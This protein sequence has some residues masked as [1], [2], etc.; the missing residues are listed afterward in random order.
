GTVSLADGTISIDS[1]GATFDF[2]A[3][4]LQWSGGTIDA[5]GGL[6]VNQ[7]TIDVTPAAGNQTILVGTL[8]N[9]A[10]V[11]QSGAG[12]FGFLNGATFQ[13]DSSGT[14]DLQTDGG[15][16]CYQ[17]DGNATFSNAGL[18]VKSM[19]TGDSSFFSV[20]NESS[21]VA[22]NNSGTLE[23]E[24][25][26]LTV[27]TGGTFTGGNFIVDTGATL[28]P[29]GSSTVTYTG[30]FTGSGG[31]S[32]T[33]ASGQITIASGGATF[34][35]PS[36]FFQWTGGTIN[37][38][39]A[40]LTNADSMTVDPSAGNETLLVGAMVNDGTVDQTTTGDFGMLNAATFDNESGATYDFLT[41]GGMGCY[42]GDGNATF[43]NSGT[44]TKTGGTGTSSFFSVPNESSNVILNNTGVV[45]AISGSLSF[46]CPVTQV[47]SDTL[48]GG[49]W[50]AI[51]GA[52][53]NLPSGTTITENDAD[54]TLEGAGAA[55]GGIAGLANNVG[56]FTVGDGAA[57]TTS[58]GLTNNGLIT[59]KS[60]SS[61]TVGGAFVQSSGGTLAYLLNGTPSSGSFGQLLVQQQATL[62][63]TVDVA[64]IN[65]YSPAVGDQFTVAAYPSVSGTFSTVEGPSVNGNQA[66]TVGVNSTDITV[67]WVAS[68]PST[69]SVSSG[70]VVGN[71]SGNNANQTGSVMLSGDN[72]IITI[73]GNTD[74]IPLS[75]ATTVDLTM[76]GGNDSVTLGEGV[77]PVSVSGGAGNDTIVGATGDDTI[78][79]GEGDDSISAISGNNV[80]S[81]GSGADT[82]K[83]G[84]GGDSLIGGLGADYLISGTGLN[85][86]SGGAGDDTIATTGGSDQVLRGGAGNNIFVDGEGT[87]ATIDGGS[88]FSY[89]QQNSGD[90]MNNILEEFD[91]TPPIS[92]P[93]APAFAPAIAAAPQDDSAVTETIIGTELFISGTPGND[94]IRVNANGSGDLL[95]HANG[96]AAVSFP[97]AGLTSIVIV[98]GAG[99]D[100]L[101]VASDVTLQARIRGN[102]GNDCLMGGGGDNILVGGIGSDT[103]VGGAG[104]N[105]LVPTLREI[106]TDGSGESDLLVGGPAGS[107]NI[108][109]FSHRTDNLYLSNDGA[110]H[111][112]VTIMPSVLNIFAGTGQ[113]TVAATAPGMFISAGVGQD[114]LVSGGSNTI[115]V[116]GPS[117]AGE[118]TVSASGIANSLFL[119]NGHEDEYEGFTMQDF[120]QDDPSDVLI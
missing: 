25:G 58:G 78:V 9:Q 94:S 95:V 106:F 108:A 116:A 21:N 47:S 74:A 79:G 39:A 53:I 105:L 109:D 3:G 102:A 97:E 66:F 36:L 98:G 65:G 67:T 77:P 43:N 56:S 90:V 10:S 28:D 29:A 118:D 34:D 91:P 63:G 103:L 4:L 85:T 35:F 111:N 23:V 68:V 75:S 110:D 96:A 40:A 27:G 107:K 87:G 89:A 26:T 82:I 32:V 1:A 13:N 113:D 57:F 70:T 6:L 16:G 46:D 24:T 2:P 8:E 83:G 73:D 69:I 120:L 71:G 119:M 41:D 42:Q 84:T 100:T 115:M 50:D 44:L 59:L 17:G 54:I 7:G 18:L 15:F 45:S 55:F 76:G 104:Q 92:P 48:T 88:G 14:Y 19:G 64:P 38:T 86:V 20:P 99:N 5:S 101:A 33:L 52:T 81:G 60:N 62:G 49:T 22:L 72:V 112:G 80:L 37:G 61:L 117:G 51:S 31:G 93:P 30:T 114:S 12:N 11:V